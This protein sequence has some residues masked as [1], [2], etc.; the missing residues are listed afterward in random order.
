M[1]PSRLLIVGAG[2]VGTNLA[3]L[4]ASKGQ[5]VTLW[6]PVS[7]PDDVLSAAAAALTVVVASPPNGSYD[8]V[9]LAVTDSEVAKV[10]RQVD[11]WPATD[12]LPL[13]HTSGS[14]GTL[15]LKSGRAVGVCHPAF[16]FP[17]PALPV[18]RLRTVVFLLD[19]PE[20]TRQ[21]FGELVR[22]W[23]NVAIDSPGANRELYHAACVTASNFLALLGANATELL[24]AAGVPE[25]GRNPLILSLMGSVLSQA[26]E[27][28][29][30][31]A[32]TGPAARGDAATIIAEATRIAQQTPEQF[33]LFLEANLS[34]LQRHGHTAAADELTA[35]LGDMDGEE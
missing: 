29:F 28:S 8:L 16:A 13:A 7:P 12:G 30:P 15:V 21:A 25:K 20:E 14:V 11:G 6:N 22:S 32:M 3:R 9:L 31:A 4:A 10:A 19:G 2:K 18:E 34:L 23:E 24:A 33:N 1:A 27:N 35:W 17:S 5:E 26:N